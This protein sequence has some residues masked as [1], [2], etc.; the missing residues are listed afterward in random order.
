[1]SN[2]DLKQKRVVDNSEKENDLKNK[3]ERIDQL[4]Q[5]HFLGKQYFYTEGMIKFTTTIHQVE[6]SKRGLF[7]FIFVTTPHFA[8]TPQWKTSHAVNS[9]LM[10]YFHIDNFEFKTNR[11]V[12]RPYTRRNH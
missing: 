3:E 8:Q 12:G 4:I 9:E 11:F 1:M 2:Q 6:K 5:K 7:K 10:K